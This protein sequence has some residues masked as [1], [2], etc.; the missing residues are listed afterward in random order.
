MPL[1]F[2]GSYRVCEGVEISRHASCFRQRDGKS[3]IGEVRST[4]T[5]H[6]ETLPRAGPREATF[7]GEARSWVRREEGCLCVCDHSWVSREEGCVR[8]CVT[9]AG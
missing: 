4:Q 7:T 8:V 1:N 3:H 6:G 9:I 2:T 5:V